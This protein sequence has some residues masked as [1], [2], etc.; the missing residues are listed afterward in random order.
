MKI[1]VGLGNPGAKYEFNRHNAGFMVVD[2]IAA[3]KKKSFKS[4]SKF[5]CDYTD[6][7]SDGEKIMLVKP[8]TYM[9][10]SGRSIRKI[11]DF[12]NEPAENIIILSDDV[13]LEFGF[14]RIR[15]N[16]GAGG[17][18]GLQSVINC[19]GTDNI[20]RIRIGIGMP[21]DNIPMEYYV[22]SDFN[23]A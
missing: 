4:S 14:I 7:T 1:I 21:E 19:V 12:Y 23:I 20:I 17:H 11:M 3:E 6:F 5:E 2:Y 10:N 8:M 18:N 13:Y 9:N 16:G 22:L 15:K